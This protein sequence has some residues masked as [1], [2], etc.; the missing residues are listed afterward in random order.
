MAY[1]PV[2]LDLRDRSC[3]IIGTGHEADRKIMDLIDVGAVVT[4][5]TSQP[6]P[7]IQEY[8]EDQKITLIK[9]GYRDGDL[10]S[11]FLAVAVTTDDLELSGRIADEAQR[12]CVLL[13]VVDVTPL[14]VWI[15]PATVRRGDLTVAISTNGLSPAMAR[16]ARERIDEDLPEEY[17]ALLE[18]LGEV[19][20]ELRRRRVRPKPDAWQEVLDGNTL[21]LLFA[22]DWD[23]VQERIMRHLDP[24]EAVTP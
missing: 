14:C 20:A 10:T 5:I 22:G 13:N 6:T 21:Q 7:L 4:A 1:Y 9:R 8:D 2:Y 16:F 23:G 24:A 18:I 3:V 11:A 17:G 15:A 12:E 19:R